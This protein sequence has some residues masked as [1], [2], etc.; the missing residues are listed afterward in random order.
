[1]RAVFGFVDIDVGAFVVRKDPKADSVLCG[2][3]DHNL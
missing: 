1:M 2:D 3:A